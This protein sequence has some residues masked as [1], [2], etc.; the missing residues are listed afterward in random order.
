MGF[1]CLDQNAR[2]EEQTRSPQHRLQFFEVL[3]AK[4]MTAAKSRSRTQHG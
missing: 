2:V 3:R 4:K 1:S